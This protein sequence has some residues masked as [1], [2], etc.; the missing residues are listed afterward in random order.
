MQN[1]KNYR[2]VFIVSKVFEKAA[3]MLLIDHLINH[4]FLD[5]FQSAYRCRHSTETALLMV[6]NDLRNAAD[7]GNISSLI[8]LDFMAAIDVIDHDKHLQTLKKYTAAELSGNPALC[9]N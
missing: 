9:I 6:L 4:Q 2:P 7:S 5:K 8:L 1:Q 3:N